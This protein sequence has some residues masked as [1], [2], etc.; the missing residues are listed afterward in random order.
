MVSFDDLL[1]ALYQ[2]Q[3]LADPGAERMLGSG[4]SDHDL[5]L[6]IQLIYEISCDMMARSGYS[7]E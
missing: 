2:I 5:A 1:G 4:D 7:P 3:G 6:K